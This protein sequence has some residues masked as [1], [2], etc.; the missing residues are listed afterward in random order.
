[1]ECSVVRFLHNYREMKCA[2]IGAEFYN[3]H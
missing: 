2:A 1:M 3:L